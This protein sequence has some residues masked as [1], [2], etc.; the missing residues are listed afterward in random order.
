MTERP[1]PDALLP[2]RGPWLLLRSIESVD[3]TSLTGTAHFGL[4]HADGHFPG[5][6]VVPGVLLLELLA[7]ASA[8]LAR[9]HAPGD[10]EGKIP[11]LVGYDRVRFRAPV[12]PPATVTVTVRRGEAVMGVHSTFGEVR[13]DG[14]R[15]CNA[16][17]RAT[18]VDPAQAQRP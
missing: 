13:I 16:E 2:H 18:Y 11:F 14:R 10:T 9:V 17:V 12:I 5:Q 6:P 4:E 8:A 7:Q 3:E 1:A 15:A